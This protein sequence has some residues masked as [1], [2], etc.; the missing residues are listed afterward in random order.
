MV[1]SQLR[2]NKIT[3]ELLLSVMAELPRERFL[4]ETLQ[5]FAYADEDLEVGTG[6]YLSEPLALARMIQQAEIQSTDVVLDI[7]SGAGYAAVAMAR[8]AGTVFAL[9]SDTAIAAQAA[10]RYAE[11][12]PDNVVAVTGPLAE[13]CAEHAPFDVI[14]IE[15]AV[16][17]VP[18]AILGQLGDGGR[19]VATIVENGVGRVTATTRSGDHFSHRVVSDSNIPRLPEFERP[20]SFSF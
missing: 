13:G 16:D 18:D 7:G 10:E 14:L 6:R 15:G 8:L 19:L 3:D 4:P 17:E 12:A 20:A 2:T 11:M 5:P 1:D 9:E